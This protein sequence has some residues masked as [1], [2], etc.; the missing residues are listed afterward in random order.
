MDER[1]VRGLDEA[2][3][4]KQLN[5]QEKAVSV[6]EDAFEQLEIRLSSVLEDAPPPSTTVA[7]GDEGRQQGTSLVGTSLHTNC[8]RLENLAARMHAL[9]S[10]LA[11]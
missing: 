2:P 1:E 6:L 10:R 7:L 5:R 8:C 4:G 9:R 11:V 3:V